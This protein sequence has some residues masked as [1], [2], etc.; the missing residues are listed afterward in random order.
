MMVGKLL[1]ASEK[2]DWDRSEE[3]QLK[4]RD[5]YRIMEDGTTDGPVSI[6]WMPRA[7]NIGPNDQRPIPYYRW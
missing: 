2:C 5:T 1:R 4:G 6:A 3:A 7:D